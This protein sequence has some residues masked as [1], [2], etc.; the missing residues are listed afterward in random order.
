MDLEEFKEQE[1][2]KE[3]D[4]LSQ[5]E[6]C[7]LTRFAPVGH[8]YFDSSKPYYKY[9]KERLEKLGG[10]TTEISKLLG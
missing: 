5:Y 10:F 8:K 4:R 9:F 6:M 7:E 3:I 1:I 2:K